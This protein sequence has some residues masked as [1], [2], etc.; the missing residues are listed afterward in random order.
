MGNEICV[1]DTHREV[2]MSDATSICSN[3]PKLVDSSLIVNTIVLEIHNPEDFKCD[4]L[5][6]GLW[7]GKRIFVS[8]SLANGCPWQI[9][10]LHKIL[11]YST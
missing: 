5:D 2:S 6:L 1:F 9:E 4:Q 7:P 8:G 3:I 11:D 10:V